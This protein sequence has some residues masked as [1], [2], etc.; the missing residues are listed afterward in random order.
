MD[1]ELLRTIIDKYQK[2]E[3][4]VSKLDREFGINI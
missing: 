2:A 1:K 3:E 4:S